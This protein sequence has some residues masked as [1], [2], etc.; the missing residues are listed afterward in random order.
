MQNTK[1][2]RTTVDG[3]D[4]TLV[5]R[6]TTDDSGGF[7]P[8]FDL[9][10]DDVAMDLLAVTHEQSQRFLQAWRERIDRQPRNVGVVSVGEQMRSATVADVPPRTNRPV[11]RGV[12]D[13]TDLDAVRETATEFL[14]AWGS[15]DRTVSYF[16]SLTAVVERH[17][18]EVATEFLETFL[19]ALDRRDAVGYFGLTPAVHD[20]AIVRE[21]ASRFDTVIECVDSPTEADAE[22]SVSDCFDV[23]SDV[24]RRCA[25]VELADGEASSVAELARR[26]GDRTATDADRVQASL[27][28]VHMPKLAGRGFVAYDRDGGRVAAG[29]HFE[30]VVPYLRKAMGGEKSR[31]AERD[32]PVDGLVEQDELVERDG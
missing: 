25:L 20:R 26:I 17:D 18:A 32:G 8:L 28:N 12:A 10:G 21:I 31:L 7:G 6:R 14:D 3:D 29:P 5:L 23:M 19:R 24:R 16:D 30:R 27:L 15:D 11:L 13:P 4:H 1:L 2:V 22:P 9:L